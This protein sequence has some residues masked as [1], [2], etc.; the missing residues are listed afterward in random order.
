[1]KRDRINAMEQYILK[2]GAVT[3]EELSEIF[4]VS[5]NTVRRDIAVLLE[6]GNFRK[7]YG[8]V[9]AVPKTQV[10]TTPAMSVR[11]AEDRHGKALI[12]RLAARLVGDNC[13][14]FLDSGSTTEKIIPH[15]AEKKNITLITYSLSAMYE[16]AK[17]PSIRLVALGGIY[18]PET[19]SFA[20]LSTIKS[21]AGM[22]VDIA[23]LSASGLSMEDG[24]SNNNY[25]E[26]EIKS[27]VVNQ[28]TGKSIVLMAD[29]RKFSRSAI[30]NYCPLSALSAIV[31]DQKPEAQILQKLQE[32][33]IRCIYAEE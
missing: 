20:G 32:E 5:M 10:A 25:L 11:V 19:M 2:N 6:R 30:F 3:L 7:V 29:S 33:N 18:H 9:R 26:A 24:L 28:C 21:M 15:L 14:I 22:R 13:S 23:F 16:A 8:G 1:M 31:T 4:H 27:A 12:G 17:Y